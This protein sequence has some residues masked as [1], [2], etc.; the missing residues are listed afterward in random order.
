ME[1]MGVLEPEDSPK[2]LMWYAFVPGGTAPSPR[3]GHTCM[4]LPGEK[5][6]GKGRIVV[7]GGADPGSCYS[8]CYIINL[9]SRC[10]KSP[11]IDGSPP[12]PRTFHTSSAAVGN[13]LFVFGGG[14]KGA[15]P[16]VDQR[17]HVFDA[18]NLTW[19]QPETSGVPPKPRHGHILVAVGTKLYVH[20]GMAGSTFF[21][22]LFCIDTETMKWKE[23][24]VKGDTPPACAAHAAVSWEKYIYIFGGVNETGPISTMHRYDTGNRTWTL[25]MF[26][27][28][29]PAARLDHSM[30]LLPWRVRTN[31]S[32]LD[33]EQDKV[34]EE[35]GTNDS[36]GH[37]SGKSSQ[38][39]L[40]L[41]F[42]GMDTCGELY[43]DCS[44]TVLT[45]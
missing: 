4:Y 37:S 6:G 3:V 43:N 34:T 12:S 10:W 41:V 5:E 16:V 22:D 27:S 14:E 30:C 40:C 24:S 38:V 39:V 33:S 26:D 28:P 8:D 1:F 18:D 32:D 11:K 29:S 23:Q 17:L 25:I 9:G 7:V 13:K 31:H 2:E 42:G 44:V 36:Q 45:K 20:G 21:K 35:G 19:T 15:D